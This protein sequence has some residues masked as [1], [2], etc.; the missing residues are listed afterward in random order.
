MGKK[1]ILLLLSLTLFL[2]TACESTET[3]GAKKL[4]QEAEVGY[5]Q[6]RYEDALQMIDSLHK[7]FPGAVKQRQ[8]ALEL[9]RAARLAQGV[10]DLAYIQPR[11]EAALHAADSMYQ[12]FELV[13]APSMPDENIIR[14][15]GYNPASQPDAPFL[16]IYID[17]HGRLDLV[18]GISAGGKLGS[19]CIGISESLGG[20][21]I[22]SDTIPYDGGMN[23]RY[24][25]LGRHYERLTFSEERA[26]ELASFVASSPAE[27][28]LRVEFGL[29][30][31]KKGPSFVLSKNARK[32][33]SETYAYYAMMKS[34]EEMQ[35]QL[36]RHEK[37]KER[38]E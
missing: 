8:A 10:R 3:K 27:S 21:H 30:S 5:Q 22:Q 33:I 18:A 6:E 34:I 17:Y 15:K 20:T 31:G 4:L 14:Y 12:A 16:D 23:Y 13:E 29:E 38:Y 25:T 19:H 32:A 2:L 36:N 7:T 35:L 26:A 9:S 11:L 28:S 37:R 1:E 24:E